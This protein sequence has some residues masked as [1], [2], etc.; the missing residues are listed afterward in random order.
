MILKYEDILFSSSGFAS[1]DYKRHD[2]K[3]R[4]D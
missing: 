2:K 4:A 1:T 3:L